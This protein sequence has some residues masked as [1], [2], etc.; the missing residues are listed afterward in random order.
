MLLTLEI[1]NTLYKIF[2]IVLLNYLQFYHIRNS[3]DKDHNF[4][5]FLSVHQNQVKYHQEQNWNY[6]QILQ[7]LCHHAIS[8]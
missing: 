4:H 7:M 5:S 6:Y 1:N 2:F 8:F 3:S